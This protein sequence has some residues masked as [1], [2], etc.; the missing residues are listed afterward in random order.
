MLSLA[1]AA[2]AATSSA[3]YHIRV[4]QLSPP[5]LEVSASF[6][7]SG[8]LLHMDSTRPAD[9]PEV[10]DKGWP[11]LVR[12]LRVTDLNGASLPVLN[13]GAD[14]WKLAHA[15]TGRV[16]VSYVVDYALLEANHWPAPREAAFADADHFVF[17]GRSL[18]VTPD[19]PLPSRV[20]FSLPTPWRAVAAWQNESAPNV[21]SANDFGE[22]TENLIVLTKV[23]PEIVHAGNFTVF[24]TTLGPWQ[25]V[26]PQVL[27]LLR[28]VVPQYVVLFGTQR[29]QN[30]S[31]VLL[32]VPDDGGESYR[33][34]FAF[35]SAAPPSPA[36][37][38]QWEHTLAHEIFHYWNGWRLRGADYAATQWFQEGFTDYYADRGMLAAGLLSPRQFRQRLSLYVEQYQQLATPMARPGTHKGPPLYSAGALVAFA[39]DLQIRATTHNARSLNTVLT[40]LWQSTDRGRLPYSWSTIRAALDAAAPADWQAFYDKYIDG[41]ERLPLTEIVSQAGLTVATSTGA[42]PAVELNPQATAAQQQLWRDV[43]AQVTAK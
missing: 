38:D 3:T 10:G 5:K 29:P 43:T 8:V 14:G 21:F 19:G 27:Q 13:A 28:G 42:A 1:F 23:A 40:S 34:S 31:V 12:D 9:V 17:V 7:M 20:D 16:T 36:N 18:F 37:I 41:S 25:S 15:V 33:A 4:L 22:L 11:A 39:W 26:R 2:D 30:Y 24:A 6:P 32:P 35:S